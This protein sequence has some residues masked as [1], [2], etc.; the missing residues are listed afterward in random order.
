MTGPNLE[1]LADIRRVFPGEVLASGGMRGEE[2]LSPV[3]SALAG[4]PMQMAS[5]ARWT[6]IESV[7]A[8]E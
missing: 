3:A 2:D 5:S 6:C 8:S 7:S 1:M 4:G